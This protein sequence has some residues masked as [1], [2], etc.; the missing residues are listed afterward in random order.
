MICLKVRFWTND[1]PTTNK[2][3]AH[4]HGVV[5]ITTN[6]SRG[7]WGKSRHGTKFKNPSELQKAI[8][9]ELSDN[10]ISLLDKNGKMVGLVGK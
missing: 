10:G 8:E 6:K 9:Q 1:L 3:T 2:K 7:I 5:T 4:E